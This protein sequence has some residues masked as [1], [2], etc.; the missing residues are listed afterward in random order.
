MSKRG[1]TDNNSI[2]LRDNLDKFKNWVKEVREVGKLLNEEILKCKENKKWPM[3]EPIGIKIKGLISEIQKL[4][5]WSEKI[6]I[7]RIL[8]LKFIG[9]IITSLYI[10]IY[11]V[12][13][14]NDKKR[15]TNKVGWSWERWENVEKINR[16]NIKIY[17]KQENNKD[18]D[19]LIQYLFKLVLEPLLDIYGDPH[20]FGYRKGRNAHMALGC[21]IKSLQLKKKGNQDT[22]Y[23]QTK[24]IFNIKSFL[25][26]NSFNWILTNFPMPYGFEHILIEWLKFNNLFNNNI[27]NNNIHDNYIENII[28][29]HPS[30]H[31][32]GGNHVRD[33]NN[34]IIS[35]LILNFILDG[36]E[37]SIYK[38]NRTIK[39]EDKIQFLK[40]QNKLYKAE[41]LF[42][43]ETSISFIRYLNNIIIITNTDKIIPDIKQI[44]NDFFIHRNIK[45]NISD[46]NKVSHGFKFNYLGFN[47]KYLDHYKKD[48]PTK[49]VDLGKDGILTKGITYKGFKQ[50][51]S[52]IFVL[53][54]SYAITYIKS[55]I[56]NIFKNLHESPYSLIKLVNP[57]IRIWGIY[58]GIGMAARIFTKI[59]HFIFYRTFRYIKRKYEKLRVLT[60]LNTYFF[61]ND[62]Y[63]SPYNRK[64]HFHGIYK[65]NVEWILLLHKI[66]QCIPVQMF[67]PSKEVYLGYY[68]I[69][70]DIY[71]NWSSKIHSYRF[72]NSI[73]FRDK[74][75]I[76]QKGKCT[77]CNFSLENCYN[78]NLDIDHIIPLV[79]GGSNHLNNLRLIH[80]N[81]HKS[82]KGHSLRKF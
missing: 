43:I 69:D 55:K 20:S 39:N 2:N 60:A 4:I 42:R 7:E 5:S 58:Y 11:V 66:V 18:K 51:K 6:K 72:K 70:P 80:R 40:E 57:I 30:G 29:Y 79:K 77:I 45:Y 14:Y 62:F 23:V 82:L 54:N 53:P 34:F 32:T 78:N 38:A 16:F 65:N 28:D 25:N 8:I 63:K 1:T 15:S 61:S 47:I 13:M 50:S 36:L 10:R 49:L 76:S 17:T 59:D 19:I 75:Y 26:H 64:Y 41:K 9:E 3:N 71:N 73:S 44:I 21:L 27:Y 56:K 74:L 12:D 68:F 35:P 52:G 22:Y 48:P 81:C 46:I 67:A 33:N 31:P 24:Y 37:E